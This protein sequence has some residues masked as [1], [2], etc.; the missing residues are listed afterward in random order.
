MSRNNTIGIVGHVTVTPK[1]VVDAADWERKVYE[2][3]LKRVRPSGAED[4]YIVQFSGRAVGS[5]KDLQKIKEGIEVLIG[6][7]IRTENAHD[8]APEENR[9]KVYIYAEVI[10]VNVPPIIDQNEVKLHGHICKLPHYRETRRRAKNGGRIAAAS[11]IV[12]VNSPAGTNYIPCACF[13]WQAVKA[14]TLEAGDEVEIYG[15][16]QSRDY[17]KHIEGRKVPYL[18]TV[19]EVSVRKLETIEKE[20]E[21]TGGKGK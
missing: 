13:G 17:R 14:K 19:Y 2:T 18:C 15:R 20:G 16:F 6:G 3:A 12:A 1:L 5:E 10:A 9:M 7:E 11:I 8:P 4:I 21:M